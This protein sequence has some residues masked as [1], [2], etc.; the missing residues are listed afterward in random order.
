[1]SSG[2]RK[3]KQFY[4]L[5]YKILEDLEPKITELLSLA[6]VLSEDELT[7]TELYK[8]INRELLLC[9]RKLSDYGYT[10]REVHFRLKKLKY[11]DF[12]EDG[13]PILSLNHI[14]R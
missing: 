12:D 6:M 5:A 7:G 11:I 4:W 10:S 3:H 1:M 14:T 13:T 2:E 9:I 8:E